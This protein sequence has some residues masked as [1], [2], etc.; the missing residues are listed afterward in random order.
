MTEPILFLIGA[1][2]RSAPFEFRE[3]IAL[4]TE[5]EAA[6]A[7]ELKRTAGLRE[8]VILSTCNRVEI[9]GVGAN[10]RVMCDVVDAFC[11]QRQIPNSDFEQFGIIREGCAAVEHL[12]RVTSGLDSQILGETEIFGQAKR[13]YAAAQAR[14][15]A[16]PILNR[17]FQKAFQAAKHVRATT[18]ITVGQVSVANV[19]VDLASTVFGELSATRL[20]VIG[21]GEMAEKSTK[22]F[23]SRGTARISV[24]NRRIERAAALA[25]ETG[26]E[27][28]CFEQ[29][30][31]K[32]AAADIVVCSTASPQAILSSEA[33]RLA[34]STRPSRPLL[35]I[36]LAMPR[37]IDSSA[38]QHENVFLYN[39]DDLAA[40]AAANRE[41]RAAQA[42]M[43]RVAV[44]RRADALW[45]QLQMQFATLTAGPS[46]VL[47]AAA[48]ALPA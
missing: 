45:A 30:H 34:M 42:E 13:A 23:H 31:E 15:T 32:L 27:V 41:A 29:R 10:G 14:G 18:G 33:V 5:A 16:G 4:G 21:A 24:A 17:L 46:S 22:A 44:A 20:L 28:V 37:D 39:L 12:C 26:A 3:R 43:G 6:M 1:T 40:I 38:G 35:L 47:M 8:F 25:R 9:Y 7:V 36:D 19:A 11:A 48:I 2:H